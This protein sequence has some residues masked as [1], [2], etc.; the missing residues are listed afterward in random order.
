MFSLYRSVLNR[1]TAA[2]C[3]LLFTLAL[4]AAILPATSAFGQATA[5]ADIQVGNSG[6]GV[7]TRTRQIQASPGQRAVIEVYGANFENSQGVEMSFVLSDSTSYSGVVDRR[8]DDGPFPIQFPLG[9]A[10]TTTND[11][12]NVTVLPEDLEGG[13]SQGSDIVHIGGVR[14]TMAEG[15]TQFTARLIRVKYTDAAVAE[16]D[17]LF[18]ITNPDAPQPPAAA[19]DMNPEAG[20][21]NLRVRR[22]NP[23]DTV[24]VQAF[25]TDLEGVTGYEIQATVDP[26]QINI[27][28][29]EFQAAPPFRLVAP[30]PDPG[31][32]SGGARPAAGDGSALI[33]LQIG[34]N[35]DSE[36]TEDMLTID[37]TPGQRVVVEVF[38]ANF[39]NS[40]GAEITF[41]LSDSTA[42]SGVADRRNDD[43]PFPI[44]FPLGFAV[45]TTNDTMKV[46]V[47]PEDLEGGIS[48]GSDMVHIGGVR[49]IMAEGYTELSLR[50]ISVKYTAT[51]TVLPNATIIIRNPNAGGDGPTGP[52][53]EIDGNTV[54]ARATTD[55]PVD[56]DQ[57][58]G[59]FRFKL[60]NAFR[61]APIRIDRFDVLQGDVR[62]TLA[63][64][65][66]LTVTP[67]VSA[68]P[69][70]VR[71]PAPSTVTDTKA[72]IVGKFN[73]PGHRHRLLRH[74]PGQPRPD[75]FLHQ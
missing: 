13:I 10:V 48:Q 46:T 56:G 57:L 23:G 11:T 7:L 17:I 29:T 3:L 30:T 49:F 12:M 68:A 9:F 64:N 69:V 35:G 60:R 67:S 20:N 70:A 4:A 15:Y 53:V 27:D 50:L 25:G 5:D 61:S 41:V 71:P 45:I 59:G 74:G 63:Q 31:D 28:L 72:F 42:Y 52:L 75:G 24:P 58:L 34:N 51:N 39:E 6:D 8:N 43:G 47:L 18:T 36:H 2:G 1:S 19:F 22:A 66:V 55:T 73:K 21:Q 26:E 32:G 65:V 37:A 16:T 62:S 44:Q 38:G 14:F 54:I 40:Q 33:D